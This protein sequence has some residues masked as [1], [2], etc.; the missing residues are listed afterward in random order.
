MFEIQGLMSIITDELC[1]TSLDAL[2]Q[3][4]VLTNVDRVAKPG[5]PVYALFKTRVVA[6]W[7]KRFAKI[8][9]ETQDTEH[10]QAGA[11]LI[12]LITKSS[13]AARRVF[14]LNVLVHGERYNR[15]I[16]EAVDLATV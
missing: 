2:E 16:A 5:N 10:L 13:D 6:F 12:P 7:K 9:M 3:K 11:I 15:L 1:K 8:P 14:D 4:T